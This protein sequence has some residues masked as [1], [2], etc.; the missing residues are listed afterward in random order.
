MKASCSSPISNRP[1][2][3]TYYFGKRRLGVG[4][5]D[6]Y[7]RLIKAEKGAV[8]SMREGGDSFG[9]RSLAVVPTK[10][11]ALFSGLVKVGAGG[12]ANVAAR[13]ARLQRRAAPDGRGDERQDKLGHADR[14]LTVRDPVVA[15][16]VLPRFL[17]PGDHAL[18]ALNINNV[19]GAAGNYT[20]TVT[21]IRPV[22][23][24]AMAPDGR[25]T[26]TLQRRPARARAGRARCDTASVSPTSR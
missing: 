11:V 9:G 22:G 24:P 25:S 14:P 6:D 17:A 19:E 21:T 5:R 8:G 3:T 12:I 2:R 1:I 16:I 4:M 7:G 13:R 23:L 26:A 18:A 20:A 10:T 15:D